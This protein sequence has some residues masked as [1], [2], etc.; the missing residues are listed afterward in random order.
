EHAETEGRGILLAAPFDV[1]LDAGR[2]V[3]QPDVLLVLRAHKEVITEERAVGAPDLVIEISSPSTATHDRQRKFR[4]YARAG[5]PEY[6]IADPN[7]KT[8][9]P[10]FLENGDYV[11]GGVFGVGAII[12][13]RVLPEFKVPVEQFF[14]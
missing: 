13:S 6:W 4:A 11:S 9:E 2:T 7:A 10:H 12:P 8:A 1:D 3:V 14:A 5:V